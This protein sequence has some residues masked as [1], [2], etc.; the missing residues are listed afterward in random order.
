MDVSGDQPARAAGPGVQLGPAGIRRSPWRRRPS[1]QPPPLPHHL[2][3]TGVGWLIAAVVLMVL[4]VLV[5]AG[6]L[7]GLAIDITVVDDVVVRWLA[8][9]QAP[10][11][12]TA[13]Q[14][15]AALGSYAAITVLLWGL[16]LALLVLRR[17]RQLLVVL[18]AWI[19]Q[20]FLIQYLLAPLVQH[21]R[22]LGVELRTDWYAWALP[23]PNW[24][25]PRST[26][27]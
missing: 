3:T 26:T 22:P 14:V 18:V 15:L 25:T 5:F 19:L 10:G 23:S 1:G 24:A 16:L 9:L 8:G 27:R 6:G 13:M 17:L 4:S 21:P 11:L 2:Q 7:H 12:L 20:G